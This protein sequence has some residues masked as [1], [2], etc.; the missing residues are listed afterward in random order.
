M[1]KW[2]LK[3][4]MLF[5]ALRNIYIE[6]I[7]E[8]L[9]EIHLGYFSRQVISVPDYESRVEYMSAVQRAMIYFYNSCLF[10]EVCVRTELT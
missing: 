9:P 5:Q 8:G 10:L 3:Y 7:T 4:E 6:F 1:Q 2:K